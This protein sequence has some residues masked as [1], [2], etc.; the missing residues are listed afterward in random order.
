[1]DKTDMTTS[2]SSSLSSARAQMRALVLADLACGCDVADASAA[3]AG[4]RSA[5]AEHDDP[6]VVELID[7]LG[8]DDAALYEELL[9][10]G[11]YDAL[12]HRRVDAFSR[13]VARRGWRLTWAE[14]DGLGEEA[15]AWA[16]RRLG[17]SVSTDDAGVVLSPATAA[18]LE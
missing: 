13:R 16:S 1:M 9:T 7:G 11:V 6:G 10:E 15:L 3:V 14:A 4:W 8:E 17:L 12:R 2:S 18:A 5:A